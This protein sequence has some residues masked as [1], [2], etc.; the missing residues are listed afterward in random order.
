MI[1]THHHNWVLGGKV[2]YAW[3]TPG[4]ILYYDFPTDAAKALMDGAGVEYCVLM[5]A[6]NSAAELEWM[7]GQASRYPHVLGVVGGGE[8]YYPQ[9]LDNIRRF[10]G[11]PAYK[12]VRIYWE[13]PGQEQGVLDEGL[14]MLAEY[15]LTC[16]IVMKPQ[17][18]AEIADAIERHPNVRF[19]LDHFA[20]V[21]IL[22]G[23]AQQWSEQIARLASLPNTTL[24][25]SGYLTAAKP[26]TLENVQ[27]YFE[28]ALQRFGANRMLYGS[29]Y[30]VCTVL[31][32]T[33][34]DTV[35][36]LRGLLA[37]LPPTE[38]AA[39]SDHT[40]RRVYRL[41]D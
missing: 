20:G 30:P 35:D 6:D 12:G 5:E 14:T 3:I 1:D 24:K 34:G 15:N 21:P 11:N 22:P 9:T 18:Y 25:L 40:A 32:Q 33:Y 39:I 29:D 41:G 7:L 36:L 38:Q 19:I 26:P 13:E 16:D 28:V 31:G 4:T 2:P 8:L 37:P 10:A 17:A 27:P 23:Q